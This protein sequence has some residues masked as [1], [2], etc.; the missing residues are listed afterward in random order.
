MKELD[1]R[2]NDKTNKIIKAVEL[3]VSTNNRN[4]ENLGIFLEKLNI[5]TNVKYLFFNTDITLHHRNGT[6][7]VQ[8]YHYPFGP[9][10]GYN[11]ETKEWFAEE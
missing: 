8:Y 3:Y 6:L 2:A 4:P 11:F 7:L 1:K 10:T 5:Q 9:F